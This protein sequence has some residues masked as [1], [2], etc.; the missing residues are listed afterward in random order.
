M[1]TEEEPLKRKPR[2]VSGPLASPILQRGLLKNWRRTFYNNVD[3]RIRKIKEEKSPKMQ[4]RLCRYLNYW[5]DDRRDVFMNLRKQLILLGDINNLWAEN[6]NCVM[7]KLRLS[8][9]DICQRKE[10]KNN[11]DIRNK[12]KDIEDFCED[13]EERLQDLSKYVTEEK[14]TD[15]NKW[16]NEKKNYFVKKKWINEQKITYD[17]NLE[18]SKN[19][20]LNDMNTFVSSLECSEISKKENDSC[21]S[22]TSKSCNQSEHLTPIISSDNKSDYSLIKTTIAVKPKATN[23]LSTPTIS[24]KTKTITKITPNTPIKSTTPT[25]GSTQKLTSTIVSIHS[26]PN[27]PKPEAL[28][29]SNS[30]FSQRGMSPIPTTRSTPKLASTTMSTHLDTSL[31]T[32]PPQ[33]ESISGYPQTDVSQATPTQGSTPKLTSTNV[34]IHL[35]TSLPKPAALKAS[36]SESSETDVSQATP[37]QGS[38][39]KLTLNNVSIHLDTS[40]PKPAALKASI[41]ESSETDV[42][43]ATPTP[44]FNITLP[45]IDIPTNNHTTIEE[46]RTNSTS[47]SNTTLNLLSNS[48]TSVNVNSTQPETMFITTV[49][50]ENSSIPTH[51]IAHPNISANLSITENTNANTSSNLSTLTFTNSS[52]SAVKSTT[53]KTILTPETKPQTKNMP[54]HAAKLTYATESVLSASINTTKTTSN[55][56]KYNSTFNIDKCTLESCMNNSLTSTNTYLNENHTNNDTLNITSNGIPATPPLIV[57]N[58]TTNVPSN[59]C[60]NSICKSAFPSLI[61]FPVC[62]SLLLIIFLFVILYKYNPIRL[63]PSGKGSKKKKKQIKRKNEEGLTNLMTMPLNIPYELLESNIQPNNAC[64]RTNNSLCKIVFEDDLNNALTEKSEENQINIKTKSDN[65]LTRE[66]LKWKI[67]LETHMMAIDECKKEEWEKSRSIFFEICLEELKK[68]GIYLD[69][70]I[71]MEKKDNITIMLEKKKFLWEQYTKGYGMILEKWKKDKWFE[72]LKREWKAEEDNYTEI[73]KEERIIKSTE[74]E[75]NNPYL[76]RQKIIWMNWVKKH[77]KWLY[78]SNDQKWFNELLEKYKIEEEEKNNIEEVD[79][80]EGN[81]IIEREIKSD[82]DAKKNNLKLKLWIEIHMVALEEYKK[83]ERMINKNEFLKTYIEELKN[84]MNP[85]EILEIEKEIRENIMLE[86]KEEE[87]NKLKR[88]N[89]FIELKLDWNNHEKKYMEELCK[90]NLPENSEERIKNSMLYEQKIIWKKYWEK[91]K[92]RWIENENM[93]KWL[94]KMIEENKNKDENEVKIKEIID[95]REEYEEEINMSKK[96]GKVKE[97][98]MKDEEG[99]I[100]NKKRSITLK[101]KP[102]RKTMIEIHMIIMEDC[103]QKE[104]ELKREKFLEICLNEWKRNESSYR[105]IIGTKS[106]MYTEESSIIA[107]NIQKMFSKNLMERHKKMLEKWRTE[108]W[109]KRLM[110]EWKKEENIYI[111]TID[112]KKFTEGIDNIMNNIAL[113]KKSEIW[114]QWIKKQRRLFTQHDKEI[115][116][117]KLL[118]EYNEEEDKYEENEEQTKEKKI[119]IDKMKEDLK[120]VNIK[121]EVGENMDKINLISKLWIEIHMMILDQRIK[122]EIGYMKKEFLKPY[123]KRKKEFEE[124]SEHGITKKEINDEE[125]E[126]IINDMIEKKKDQWECWKREEWFQ[127]LKLNWYKTVH[128]NDIEESKILGDTK[129]VINDFIFERQVFDRQWIEKQ[130]KFLK[131][132]NKRRLKKSTKNRYKDDQIE[133]ENEENILED[134]WEVTIL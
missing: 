13:K 78:D 39:P 86:N 73:I 87:L 77:R 103:K 114:N 83:E 30:G 54:P 28:K 100:K 37:T 27:L 22:K 5:V 50:S 2:H 24:P 3:L 122:E 43:P 16:L 66:Q 85:E 109:F 8:I 58:G 113:G 38:T 116:F 90:K 81:I 55:T 7:E 53:S 1:N 51:T 26:D 91:T 62:A 131:K 15:Y 20:T 124:L 36:I 106:I 48:S 33:I 70:T 123:I 69:V 34:S 101:K 67:I 57:Q 59:N 130:R 105:N 45:S 40:L 132:W 96:G 41:S 119:N 102:K 84:T 125:K 74:N 121:D 89:W 112:R 9:N 79:S 61:V 44:G 46:P 129:G 65:T 72:N 60:N 107:L 23:N 4:R 111:E 56:M 52:I 118:D 80:E 6:Q 21:D 12:R 17:E 117:N 29:A 18:I 71:E 95:K 128:I 35:D 104:W 108:E 94:I 42:S 110:E 127:E 115:L 11:K 64:K 63:L 133:E 75:L 19:C 93:E 32:S 10:N 14:C 134:S 47:S 126:G 98:K 25:E 88:E 99:Q 76:E 31:A 82:K 92:K 120:I 68:E 97:K 49:S